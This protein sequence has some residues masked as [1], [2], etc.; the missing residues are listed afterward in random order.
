M[1]RNYFIQRSIISVS[2][3]VLTGCMTVGP[4]YEAPKVETWQDQWIAADTAVLEPGALKDSNWWLDF[5]DPLLNEM[6]VDT[7]TR[8]YYPLE[9]QPTKFN[10][11]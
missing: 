8:N 11:V 4:E 2:A 1:N 10:S 9:T 5:E 6:I 3:L 7:R